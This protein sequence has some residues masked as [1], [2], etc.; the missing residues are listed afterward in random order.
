MSMLNTTTYDQTL[1][2]AG[3]KVTGDLNRTAMMAVNSYGNDPIVPSR[4]PVVS[5]RSSQVDA[6]ATE[7]RIDGIADP[8]PS[9]VRPTY[10]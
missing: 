4:P 10:Q 2:S 3:T 6:L 1:Q 5:G 7:K 9:M 8:G